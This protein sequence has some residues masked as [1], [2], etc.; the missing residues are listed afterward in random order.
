[1]TRTFE[2]HSLPG[3]L[4]GRAAGERNLRLGLISDYGTYVVANLGG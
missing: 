3:V 4:F 1:M 2:K